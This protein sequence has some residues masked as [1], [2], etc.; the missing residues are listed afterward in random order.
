MR[1][2][3]HRG[4][5]PTE[6]L[7]LRQ[8]PTPHAPQDGLLVRVAASSPNPVDWHLYR[9]EPVTMRLPKFG[10]TR[11]TRGIGEDF[12]G[13]VA[14]VGAEVTGF[15]VGQHVFG[16]V[17]AIAQIPGSIAEYVPVS[18]QWV[19]PLPAA[20]DPL[21]SATIGLAGLTALQALRERGELR[22]GGRV[23]VWG[24]SG[25]VGHLAVQIARL[26]G[27]S[28]VDAVCSSR[29]AAFVRSLGADTIIDYTRDQTPTGPYDVIVD[30]VCTA[31]PAL[32]SQL[33]TPHGVIVTIG[34]L[35]TGHLLGPAAP[36]ARRAVGAK[37]RGFTSR[38]VL[39]RV[40]AEDLALLASWMEAG[41]LR[42][43]IAGT[44]PLSDAVGAYQRLE[45]GR[46]QGKLAIVSDQ[47]LL[48]R[49]RDTTGN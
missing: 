20:V 26:L 10:A 40:N 49:M 31:S 29:S 46:V 5:T 36:M 17:P 14:E 27:A 3:V 8:V 15:S 21:E 43:T 7:Q 2:L 34:A 18:T 9:G 23:L 12:S 1:A 48:D 13:V 30:T 4:P 32:V 47:S 45:A 19:A 11:A 35:G 22:A 33:L 24:A 25:G 42:V 16:T 6:D 37:L 28:R 44:Y 39:T 41:S 38:T